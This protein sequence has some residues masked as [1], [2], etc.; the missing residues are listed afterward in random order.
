MGRRKAKAETA[1][2]LGR[3]AGWHAKHQA[4]P[5]VQKRAGGR[6]E[7]EKRMEGEHKRQEER[8]QRQLVMIPVVTQ[9]GDQYYIFITVYALSTEWLGVNVQNRNKEPA[10]WESEQCDWSYEQPDPM[11]QGV[12]FV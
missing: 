2:G 1:C 9:V 4:L 11:F 6:A 5:H 7:S 3:E 10:R 8:L 12:L